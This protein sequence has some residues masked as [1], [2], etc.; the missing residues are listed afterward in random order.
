MWNS[1]WFDFNMNTGETWWIWLNFALRA[2]VGFFFP[3]PSK[4]IVEMCEIFPSVTVNIKPR[5]L[6]FAKWIVGL[7]FGAFANLRPC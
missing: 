5:A 1:V 3:K 4:G 7:Q 6:A 2:G